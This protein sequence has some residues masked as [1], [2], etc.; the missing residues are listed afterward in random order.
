MGAVTFQEGL[1]VYKGFLEKEAWKREFR[2]KSLGPNAERH[3]HAGVASGNTKRLSVPGAQGP[4]QRGIV[5]ETLRK[6][7]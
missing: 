5:G 2:K 3:K 4:E 6:V 1:K 7:S